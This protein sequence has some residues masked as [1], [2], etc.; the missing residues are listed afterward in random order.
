MAIGLSAEVCFTGR[1]R[2]V[3]AYT[4]RFDEDQGADRRW[5]R[6]WEVVGT[7]A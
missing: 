3:L 6:A 2:I 1:W 4:R 7:F 5:Q